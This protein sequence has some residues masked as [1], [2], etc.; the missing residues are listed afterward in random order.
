MD[1]TIYYQEIDI[2]LYR[3]NENVSIELDANYSFCTGFAI[4][5]NNTPSHLTKIG[6]T[7][8]GCQILNKLPAMFLNSTNYKYEFAQSFIPLDIE[9]QKNILTINFEDGLTDTGLGKYHV[10][11]ML[12]NKK[13]ENELFDY[14]YDAIKLTAGSF[15]QK[16]NINY[17]VKRIVGLNLYQYS[18]GILEV[19]D[20]VLSDTVRNFLN[21]TNISLFPNFEYNGFL[22]KFIKIHIPTKELFL[23]GLTTMTTMFPIEPREGDTLFFVYKFKKDKNV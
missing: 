16:L 18:S 23:K 17:Q 11:L 21:G 22:N 7:Y 14:D 15:S 6:L 13:Q 5:H 20:I 1:E 2:E 3:E 12:S 10:I 8:K 4:F 19:T 9:A